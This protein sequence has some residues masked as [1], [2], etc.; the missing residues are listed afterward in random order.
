M[1]AEGGSI[2]AFGI[3]Y[4]TI[5]RLVTAAGLGGGASGAA[6]GLLHPF[7]PKGRLVRVSC[8]SICKPYSMCHLRISYPQYRCTAAPDVRQ[9]YV[10]HD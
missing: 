5:A 6:A 9:A 8:I 3:L 7:S 10:L 1:T 2:A 4:G